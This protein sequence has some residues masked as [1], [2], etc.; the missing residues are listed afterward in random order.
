MGG[1]QFVLCAQSVGRWGGVGGRGGG[2]GWGGAG[3]GHEQ[4]EASASFSFWIAIFLSLSLARRSNAEGSERTDISLV[5]RER[6]RPVRCRERAE[7]GREGG[8]E[9]ALTLFF[10]L[11]LPSFLDLH[12]I[13]VGV[14]LFH[15]GFGFLRTLRRRKEAPPLP[16]D[17]LRPPPISL[18]F[19]GGGLGGGC[20]AAAAAAGAP[21]AALVVVVVVAV[22][23]VATAVPCPA[24][25]PPPTPTT[26]PTPTPASAASLA[27]S[28]SHNRAMMPPAPEGKTIESW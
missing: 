24:P 23:L 15:F 10:S 21:A 9:G 13:I 6:Y 5:T 22:V 25:A 11:S 17:G 14:S 2:G 20:G 26:P 16:P 1:S 7:G 12:S 4:G 19:L 27:P 3:A 28:P 18:L 8:R